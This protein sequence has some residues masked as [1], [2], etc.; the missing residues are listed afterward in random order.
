[1]RARCFT[2]WPSSYSAEAAVQAREN[3]D[4]Q[5]VQAREALGL[6]IDQI[7]PSSNQQPDLEVELG[8]GLDRPQIG[9]SANLVGDGVRIA[10]VGLVLAATVPWRARLTVR[11]GRRAWR[12]HSLPCSPWQQKNSSAPRQAGLFFTDLRCTELTIAP[13]AYF[14]PFWER[15]VC[16]ATRPRPIDRSS[17]MAIPESHRFLAKAPAPRR[18]IPSVPAFRKICVQAATR[19]FTDIRGSRGAEGKPDLLAASNCGPVSRRQSSR[20][21]P[22]VGRKLPA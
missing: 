1:M 19:T 8:G 15:R 13:S 5:V 12:P 2:S 17:V 16:E 18:R 14:P 11:P 3:A 20:S 6:G 21:V 10:G 4:E 7:A 9:A 22:A